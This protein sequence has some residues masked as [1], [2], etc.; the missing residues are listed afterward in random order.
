MTAP[1]SQVEEQIAKSRDSANRALREGQPLRAL[2]DLTEARRFAPN[3]AG[4]VAHIAAVEASIGLQENALAGFLEASRLSP[5]WLPPL[6]SALTAAMASGLKDVADECAQRVAILAPTDEINIAARLALPAIHESAQA[7]QAARRGYSTALDESI[8][9]SPGIEHPEIN[10]PAPG[11]FLAY[12]GENNR[13]LKQRLARLFLQRC[14]QLQWEAADVRSPRPR[15]RRLRIGFVSRFFREHSIARTSR[16]VMARLSRECF[17]VVAIH[18]PLQA[19]DA[20]ARWIRAHSDACVTLD[21]NLSTA[22]GQIAALKLDVLFYQDIGMEPRSYFLAFARLAPVQCVSFGHPDT[23]GIPNID[24]FI[25]NDVYELPGAQ[26]HYS[27]R[28]FL[29]RNLPTL[30]YY[31]RPAV[32][33]RADARAYFGLSEQ[34]HLYLCPQ[35]LFKL[36]PDFDALLSSILRRD[37]QGRILLIRNVM[38]V[39][40]QQLTQRFA[41]V[42]PELLG[43]ITFLDAMP[44]DRFLTLL[45]TAD[46]VLDTLHFNGMNSSLEAFAAGTPVVTLPTNLQCGRHTAAMYLGMGMQNCIAKTPEEYVSLAVRLGTDPGYRAEFSARIHA[47]SHV[48]FE[49]DRVVAEFERFFS[50]AVQANG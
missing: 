38:N 27:E 44:H 37:P 30:A 12:H 13:E 16:G 21:T 48:L 4:L 14:P 33:Y 18:I 29:L 42:M 24:Y 3:D 10:F 26:A 25:S 32:E 19:E 2:K 45:A 43:R 5:Y 47:N 20:T 28:L 36:H 7:I 46:V 11:F 6:R 17:E 40:A 8:T 1:K 15:G 50:E 49:N 41:R 35:T 23:T 39:W 31:Y 34:E 9:C 22:R